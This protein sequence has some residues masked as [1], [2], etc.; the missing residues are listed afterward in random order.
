MRT[1][2][3]TAFAQGLYGAASMAGGGLALVLVPR[4][5]SWE[6]PFATAAILAG[7]GALVLAAAPRVAARDAPVARA[8]PSLRDRR[9]LRLAAMH[10]ASFGLSV[11]VANWVVTLLERNDD[12]SAEIA[13]RRRGA[14][15]AARHR[16]AAGRRPG[17]RPRRACC[18]RASSPAAPAR[19][20]SRS[21]RAWASRSSRRPSSALRP[22][23][24][25]ASSF[26]DAARV[27]P[28]APGAAIGLVNMA[29]AV[30][31][32]VGT[33]L[34][35]LS[36][37]LPGDGTA[38]LRGRRRAVGARRALRARPGWIQNG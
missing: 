18:A 26:T 22:G 7:V 29:A 17:L 33:P 16:H 3:G 35:G 9:L 5:G 32:L 23:I 27:L 21:A 36:F 2:I 37:S 12:A 30:T 25:F 31:I 10:S 24:P 4:W 15:A 20:S 28:D 1:T 34:V 13:G 38:R 19:R 11:V 6:A 8:L 14:D